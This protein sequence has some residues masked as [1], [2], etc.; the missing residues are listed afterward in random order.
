MGGL[1]RNKS[2]TFS[3]EP[4]HDLDPGIF[5]V[6]SSS[7]M[8]KPHWLKSSHV[9]GTINAYCF[10]YAPTGANRNV[11]SAFFHVILHRRFLRLKSEIK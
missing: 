1:T 2:F 4:D 11:N 7:E 10:F 6:I 8:L 5:I 9:T 3:A